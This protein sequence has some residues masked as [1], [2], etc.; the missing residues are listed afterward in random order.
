MHVPR[1]NDGGRRAARVSGGEDAVAA[2]EREINPVVVGD[3][4]GAEDEDARVVG[5]LRGLRRCGGDRCVGVVLVKSE[6]PSP[7]LRCRAAGVAGWLSALRCNRYHKRA[8][9]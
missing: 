5:V 7:P 2:R 1:R 4:A 3:G 8:I 6:P 9:R